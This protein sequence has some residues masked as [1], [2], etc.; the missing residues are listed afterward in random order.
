MHELV[1]ELMSFEL[2]IPLTSAVSSLASICILSGRY[3]YVRK[4]N[5]INQVL[6]QPLECVMF[7]CLVCLVTTKWEIYLFIRCNVS[8][9]PTAHLQLDKV[10]QQ[11][12]LVFL[13]FLEMSIE[14][15][16]SWFVDMI[17]LKWS[18]L[19]SSLLIR[20]TSEILEP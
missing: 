4:N 16:Q 9:L 8:C 1:I 15:Q 7:G 13:Q 18:R 6:L 10:T 12:K 20:W 2:V 19:W 3:G 17:Q 14:F 5:C 11:C